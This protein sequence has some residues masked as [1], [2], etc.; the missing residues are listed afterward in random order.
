MSAH[1]NIGKP[2][3]FGFVTMKDAESVK[4]VISMAEHYID[5]KKVISL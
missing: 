3:G 1:K 5:S 4:S 2:R